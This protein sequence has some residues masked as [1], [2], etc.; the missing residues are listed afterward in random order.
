ME[1]FIKE[2]DYAILVYA[3]EDTAKYTAA[4]KALTETK[5]MSGWDRVQGVTIHKDCR[6][7]SLYHCRCRGACLGVAGRAYYKSGTRHKCRLPRKRSVG[8][9]QEKPIEHRR[10]VLRRW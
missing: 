6:I 7:P 4:I 3:K 1:N 5:K 8:L 2:H 9:G 10:E